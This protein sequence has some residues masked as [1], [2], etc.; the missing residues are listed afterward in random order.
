[1]VLCSYRRKTCTFCTA[2][3][4]TS[5]IVSDGRSASKSTCARVAGSLPEVCGRYAEVLAVLHTAAYV[6]SL[7]EHRYFQTVMR[8]LDFPVFAGAAAM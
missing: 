8:F 4:Y 5:Y 1:M 6:R 7:L 2:S 3:T